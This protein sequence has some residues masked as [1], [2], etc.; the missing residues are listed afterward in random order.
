M[1]PEK[2]QGPVVQSVD[3]AIQ[4]INHYPADSCC[5]KL[6]GYLLN[7]DYSLDS[8]I[9]SLNNWVLA[10]RNSTQLVPLPIAKY[11]MKTVQASCNN[12]AI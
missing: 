5:Q 2:L 7:R 8:I 9:H 3:N 10:F 11:L 4:Q 1:L 6:L 12:I